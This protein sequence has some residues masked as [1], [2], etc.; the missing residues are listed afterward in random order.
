TVEGLEPGTE[1]VFAVRSYIIADGKTYKSKLVKLNCNTTLAAVTGISQSETTSSSH[2]LSWKSVKGADGYLIYFYN[3]ESKKYVSIGQ[4]TKN[5]C[6]LTKLS[7][8]YAYT[9]KIR[10][11]SLKKDS[12]KIYSKFSSAFNAVTLPATPTLSVSSVTTSSFHLKWKGTDGSDGY[13]IY[14][15]DPETKKYS[16]VASVKDIYSLSISSKA[17]AQSYTYAIKSYAKI[18]G[19][20]YYSELSEPLTVTTKPNAPTAKI[21]TDL[22][23]NGN[24]KVAWT[25]VEGADGYL[26]YTSDRKNSGFVL[27]KKVSA[28][29]LEYTLTGL[30]TSKTTYIKIKAF[31]SV[32]DQ[33]IYSENSKLIGAKA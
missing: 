10:A 1:Y 4:T 13:R 12:G 3:T 28:K 2:R 32:G 26:I 24:I 30:S 25:K 17:S 15:R 22:P 16:L 9:Y 14:E 31:I 27:K 6:K 8:A 21:K 5:T 33:M 11:F 18:N 19:K 20:N 29:T 7:S 23:G